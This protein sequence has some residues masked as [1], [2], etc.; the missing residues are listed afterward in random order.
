MDNISSAFDAI[1]VAPDEFLDS[2]LD[3]QEQLQQWFS[4]LG[5]WHFRAGQITMIVQSYEWYLVNNV[6]RRHNVARWNQLKP[7]LSSDAQS[8]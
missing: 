3:V 5:I 8:W 1:Q 6:T 2:T 7:D 4:S